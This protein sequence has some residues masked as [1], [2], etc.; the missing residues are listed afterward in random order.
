MLPTLLAGAAALTACSPGEQEQLHGMTNAVQGLC[1]KNSI[2]SQKWACVSVADEQATFLANYVGP[3][4]EFKQACDFSRP[5][6]VEGSVEAVLTANASR[7]ERC[8]D[9]VDKKASAGVK[10]VSAEIRNGLARGLQ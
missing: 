5:P 6:E 1:V 3:K 2:E 4:G 7:I 10:A 8:L 9:A